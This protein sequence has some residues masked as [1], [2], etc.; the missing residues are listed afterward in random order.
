MCVCVNLPW[1]GGVDKCRQG[2]PG[3]RRGI[4]SCT[5]AYIA[6]THSRAHTQTHAHS[7]PRRGILCVKHDRYCQTG[8]VG[9]DVCGP[10]R[11]PSPLPLSH[12]ARSSTTSTRPR[13]GK[14]ATHRCVVGAD[15]PCVHARARHCAGC[16]ARPEARPA[17]RHGPRALRHD[18]GEQEE[19]RGDARGTRRHTAARLTSEKPSKMSRPRAPCAAP[20]TTGTGGGPLQ[21]TGAHRRGRPALGPALGL[22]AD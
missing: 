1:C 9:E 5:Y 22:A 12:R 6:R 17:S 2:G 20:C 21:G 15:N 8:C 13:S 3:P 7:P 11:A 4:P 14:P 10:L 16:A 19:G 18:G